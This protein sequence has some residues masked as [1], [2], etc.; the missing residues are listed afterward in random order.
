M[1][2]EVTCQEFSH[3]YND[4]NICLWTDGTERTLSA[5]EAAC[6]QRN[7]FL[8]R[9]TNSSIQSKLADFRIAANR[10]SAPAELLGGSGFWIDVTAVNI[11]SW[12]WV[13]GSQLAGWF[14]STRI[15]RNIHR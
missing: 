8:P 4:V 14:V 6:Q 3:C 13:D 15:K 1:T 10:F 12:H 5:A 11:S 2:R 9:V 7:S